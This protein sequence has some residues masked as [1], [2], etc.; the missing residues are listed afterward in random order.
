MSMMNPY[1]NYNGDPIE[2]GFIK[3]STDLY[4][5]SPFILRKTHMMTWDFLVIDERLKNGYHLYKE[6]FFLNSN[7]D[8]INKTIRN[9]KLE[10]LLK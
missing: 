9:Y 6:G 4:V 1:E 2:I 5:K 10:E 7:I 8:Y 3:I